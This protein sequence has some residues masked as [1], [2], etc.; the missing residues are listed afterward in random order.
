MQSTN[1]ICMLYIERA[2]F[3]FM[4]LLTGSL[5]SPLWSC[6]CMILRGSLDPVGIKLAYKQQTERASWSPL[7]S[8]VLMIFQLCDTQC[9][10]VKPQ[11][12]SEPP[13]LSTDKNT[14]VAGINLQ[15]FSQRQQRKRELSHKMEEIWSL[16]NLGGRICSVC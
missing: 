16:N 15:S 1:L 9:H 5:T 11:T 10:V 14:D 2:L 7:I 4:S 3:V 13:P 12:E 8:L 6:G